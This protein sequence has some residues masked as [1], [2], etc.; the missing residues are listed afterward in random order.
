MASSMSSSEWKMGV[1]EV[2]SLYDNEACGCV[3]VLPSM[4]HV[5]DKSL[6]M[7]GSTNVEKM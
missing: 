4:S 7:E 1:V 5:H 2:R 6:T 3:C